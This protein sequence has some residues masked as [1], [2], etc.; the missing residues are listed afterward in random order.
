MDQEGR[1]QVGRGYVT[2]NQGRALGVLVLVEARLIADE[3]TVGEDA[4]ARVVPLVLRES[5]AEQDHQVMDKCEQLVNEGALPADA[6]LDVLQ[7]DEHTVSGFGVN[8]HSGHAVDLP[9]A[10]LLVLLVE[11]AV[12]DLECQLPYVALYFR[13]SN[14]YIRYKITSRNNGLQDACMSPVTPNLKKE[15]KGAISN[16]ERIVRIIIRDFIERYG[17]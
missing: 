7:D 10:P 11:V 15:T 9:E 16:C 12:V 4:D 14:Y 5:L 17:R 3:G 2:D 13:H 1:G 6:A 8:N